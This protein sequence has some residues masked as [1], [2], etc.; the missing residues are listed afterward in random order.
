MLR[1]VRIAQRLEDGIVLAVERQQ[2]GAVP[3]HGLHDGRPGAD[4]SLLVGERDGAAGLDGGERR[5]H[6]GRPRDGTDHEVRGPACGFGHGLR[7]GRAFD[8][9]MGQRRFQVQVTGSVGQ[10]GEAGSERDRGL[11]QGLRVAASCD[12]GD[13]EA[14][15]MQ[16][17]DLRR[18]ATDRTRRAEDRNVLRHVSVR[19]GADQIVLRGAASR[20]HLHS[21][22]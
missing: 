2:L 6:A 22:H 16:L 10:G 8:L 9:G 21:H 20:C 5:H 11:G 12:S 7:A 3:R 13:P 15:G 14:V 1:P 4:Q 18:G 17:E 19:N